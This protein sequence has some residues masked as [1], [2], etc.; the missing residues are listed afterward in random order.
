MNIFLFFYLFILFVLLTPGTIITLSMLK[1]FSGS[2][3]MSIWVVAAIHGFLFSVIA[4]TTYSFVNDLYMSVISPI[5]DPFTNI[6]TGYTLSSSDGEK[7][8]NTLSDIP[9]AKI[10][11]PS[12]SGPNIKCGKYKFCGSADPASKR[13][14]CYGHQNGCLWGANDCNND[15]DC[16]KYNVSSA[17]YTDAIYSS[18]YICPNYDLNHWAP[19]FCQFQKLPTKQQ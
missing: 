18:S 16:S 14:Y 8:F 2:K 4:I 1:Q 7:P 5:Q 11:A 17:K 6:N 10:Q 15:A 3:P 13:V 12:G 19:E 9:P